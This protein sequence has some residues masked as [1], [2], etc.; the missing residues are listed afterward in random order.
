MNDRKIAQISRLQHSPR[1]Q[2]NAKPRYAMHEAL[3]M[4]FLKLLNIGENYGGIPT[5]CFSASYDGVHAALYPPTSPQ[6]NIVK[7]IKENN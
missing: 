1:P 7:V 4:N 5:P 6:P 3:K 2:L